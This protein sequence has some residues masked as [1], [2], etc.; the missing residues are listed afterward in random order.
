MSPARIT[1]CVAL[2]LL[3][4]SC[5][6]AD[7]VHSRSAAQLV[8]QA[9]WTAGAFPGQGSV[10]WADWDGDGD[11]DLPEGSTEGAQP[12]RVYTSDGGAL[13]TTPAW[14]SDELGEV[15]DLLRQLQRRLPRVPIP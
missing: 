12:T 2:A 10:A 6:P 15:Y 9:D 11:V 5:G 14:E 3:A 8:D 7:V 13:S 4:S 1:A